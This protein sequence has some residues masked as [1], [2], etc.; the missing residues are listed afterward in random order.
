MIEIMGLSSPCHSW[1]GGS[2]MNCLSIKQL[3]SGVDKLLAKR[4][5]FGGVNNLTVF[6]T[7]LRTVNAN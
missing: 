6:L 4:D 2:E 7:L 5:S 1:L 3:N